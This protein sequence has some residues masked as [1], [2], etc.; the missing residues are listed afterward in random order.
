MIDQLDERRAQVYIESLIVEVTGDNA[1]EF[2][3]QWQGILASSS[4][5]NALIGGT[6]YGAQGNL[7]D[8]TLAQA[9]RRWRQRATATAR[10]G[11]ARAHS[12]SARA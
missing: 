6:N 5:T 12:R 3:F 8:I 2:G 10:R 7:L 9:G 11:A 1:A 4:N